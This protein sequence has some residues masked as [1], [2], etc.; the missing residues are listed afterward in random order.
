MFET[1]TGDRALSLID[2]LESNRLSFENV[3]EST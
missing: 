3:V 2:V 1:L